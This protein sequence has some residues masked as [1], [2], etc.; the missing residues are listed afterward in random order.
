MSDDQRAAFYLAI[1]DHYWKENQVAT[2]IDYFVK[3]RSFDKAAAGIKKIGIDWMVR[4]RCT[5]LATALKALP[6][7]MVSR[8]P[9][10]LMLLTL[11]KY[12]KV[13]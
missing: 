6:P 8:D 10:L 13:Q 5:D 2:A 9:W 7:S 3:A 11:I 4:G 12:M 1:A